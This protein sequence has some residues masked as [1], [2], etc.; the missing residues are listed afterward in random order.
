MDT[1]S[2]FSEEQKDDH[3]FFAKNKN[4]FIFRVKYIV[5]PMSH[6]SLTN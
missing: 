5:H 3:K 6:K 1:V 4:G 2:Y